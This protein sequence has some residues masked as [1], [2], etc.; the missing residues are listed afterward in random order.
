M[1][2][3]VVNFK[4]KA[5]KIK[6]LH[7][8]K[9]IAQMNNYHFKLVK[10]KREFIWHQHPETDEVFIVIEGT[11]SIELR[12]KTLV[13][14]EGEMVAIPKGTEH[15]PICKEVVCCLLIEPAGTANTGNAG[16]VLTDTDVDWI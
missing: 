12:E 13:L 8:Y 4:E 3:K 9:I 14:H 10:T 16:G 15:K 1:D 5:C 7:K 6:E 2:I 11:L